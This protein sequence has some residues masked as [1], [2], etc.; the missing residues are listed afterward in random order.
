MPSTSAPGS[1]D[2]EPERIIVGER[3]RNANLNQSD[4]FLVVLDTYQDRQNGFVFG[5]NPGG[6]E[7]DGQVREGQGAGEREHQLGRELERGHLPGR[8]GMVR[9][10]ADPLL[11]PPLRPQEIQTGG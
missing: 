4:A 1:R 3:R 7:Y 2:R 10:D 9:R 6:I 8:A 11:H 5:T